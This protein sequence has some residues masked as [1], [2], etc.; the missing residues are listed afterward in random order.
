MAS[1]N[2]SP[3]RPVRQKRIA[4]FSPPHET[5]YNRDQSEIALKWWSKKKQGAKALEKKIIEQKDEISKLQEVLTEAS[6]EKQAL[7][8]QVE[9]L[10]SKKLTLE[11]E[12]RSLVEALEAKEEELSVLREECDAARDTIATLHASLDEVQKSDNHRA[13]ALLQSIEPFGGFKKIDDKPSRMLALETLLLSF[14]GVIMRKTHPITRLRAICDLLFEKCIFGVV[15]TKI[16]LDEIYKKHVAVRHRNIFSP[17]KILR[18]IDLSIGGC[19]NYNGVEVL[20]SV[21]GLERYERGI[22]PSRSSIQRCAY[23][24]HT[25]GQLHIPFEKKECALGECFAYDYEKLVRFLLQSFS[26]YDVAQRETVEL[27]ITL[28]GAE[29]CDGIQHLTAGVKITDKR[30]IDPKDG[31][32]LSISDGVL[33]RI[34]KVQS[35]NYCFAMKSLLGKDCKSAYKEFSDF[36]LFFERLK[37]YGLPESDLGPAILP[38]DIWS[39]QDLSSIW[40]SLNTGSGAKKNGSNHFCH[41]CACTGSTIAKYRVDQNRYSRNN[42]VFPFSII[43]TIIHL[44]NYFSF[45]IRCDKCIASDR[46]H[47]YHWNVGDEQSIAAFQQELAEQLYTYLETCGVPFQEIKLK[48]KIIYDPCDVTRESNLYNIDF[49]PHGA[50]EEERFQVQ[51]FFSNLLTSEL[52]MRK[53]QTHGTLEERRSRLKQFLMVE[54]KLQM[55]VQAISRGQ[56]GKEA[57]MILIMQA[58]PCIMHLENRVGEKLITVLLAMGAERFHEERGI[59][60]LRRFIAAVNHVVNTRILGTLI[61]PKQWKVPVNDAGDAVTKVSLSNKKTRLFVDNLDELI[62]HIFSNPIHEERKQIWKRM[63]QNYREA[64]VILRQPG[65][66]TDDDINNF[67]TKIDDFFTA[68]VETSGA[69]KEGITNYLHML[70]SSHISYYMKQ[71]RN[72]YK[73]SQQG[74]E[75][76]NEK[77]KLIFFN[78]SQRGGNYGNN[79]SEN[80]RNYLKTIFMAF[81]R[82]ILWMSGLAENYFMEKNSNIE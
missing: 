22:L 62:Q 81:Q 33:G 6:E 16:V 21:E 10:E 47:C 59:R 70:G 15:A 19:L 73:F 66:Y 41:L 82:E 65:E 46:Q 57:A 71:H 3:P 34:F 69:G 5:R 67:Q 51:S 17:W 11:E 1:T 79:V 68:Y 35:R 4:E 31:A 7:R 48:T 72:L 61:R 27:C 28:D 13:S 63:V 38:M 78:H 42:V 12:R 20:R 32:P 14:L 75:S 24:L 37:K 44:N 54:E 43:P 49:I 80:D 23:E 58:I 53:L 30:A 74:W 39:P 76:L 40:K 55:I 52:R 56:E 50:T 2:S 8:S 60:S 64:M 9:A 26:L 25:L 18:A 77:F 36:F 29:L 45:F